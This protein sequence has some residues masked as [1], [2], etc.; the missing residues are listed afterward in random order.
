[1]WM[2]KIKLFR[3]GK[4]VIT[5]ENE[6]ESRKFRRIKSVVYISLFIFALTFVIGLVLFLSIFIK[7]NSYVLIASAIVLLLSLFCSKIFTIANKKYRKNKYHLVLNEIKKRNYKIKYSNEVTGHIT[8]VL[9][10]ENYP[11]YVYRGKNAK[12]IE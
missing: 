3:G 8:Y 6:E 1:M 11:I 9:K 2:E 7:F 10:G 12:G 4:F 5:F